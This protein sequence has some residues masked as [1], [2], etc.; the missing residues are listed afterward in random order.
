MTD[1]RDNPA[2]HRFE[3]D[4]EAGPAIVTYRR[5]GG[6]LKLIHTEVPKA[7][8]GKGVGSALAKG[9][10]D[11]IRARGDKIVPLCDFMRGY[12]GRHPEYADLVV[13]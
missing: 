1:I 6:V 2:L 3:M 4:T 8:G 5:E 11:M 7:L 9:V 10:L 13:K 12:I